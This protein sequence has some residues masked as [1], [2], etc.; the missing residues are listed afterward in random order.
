MIW[1]AYFKL[2]DTNKFYSIISYN[3]MEKQ[4]YSYSI[5]LLQPKP[6]AGA[7]IATPTRF[8]SC[9]HCQGCSNLVSVALGHGVVLVISSLAHLQVQKDSKCRLVEPY[10]WPS[11]MLIQSY[12]NWASGPNISY[13]ICGE[14][15]LLAP[16]AIHLLEDWALVSLGLLVTLSCFCFTSN[17]SV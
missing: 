2:Y 10:C 1:I 15:K 16:M 6:C 13:M 11:L 5:G 7:T 12:S 3:Y 4:H 17:G 14:L 8:F 9:G